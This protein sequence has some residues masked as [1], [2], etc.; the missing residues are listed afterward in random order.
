MTP[1]LPQRRT[2]APIAVIV[3]LLV[4]GVPIALHLGAT[5]AR[6]TPVPRVPTT[7]TSVH[8][9]QHRARPGYVPVPGAQRGKWHTVFQ[10]NF[11]G[12]GRPGKNWDVMTG[13]NIGAVPYAAGNVYLN[14]R[15]HLLIAEHHTASGW[16]SGYVESTRSFEPAPGQSLLVQSRLSMPM[17][18]SLW[19]AFWALA[20]AARHTSAGEPAAGEVDIAESIN[21]AR[22][23]A[24]ILHCGPGKWIG[25][26]GGTRS[27][28]YTDLAGAGSRQGMHTYSWLWANHGRSS[29]IA[30]YIDGQ[31][32]LRLTEARIGA[33]YWHLAFD[34]PYFILYDLAIGGWAQPISHSTPRYAAMVVDSVRVLTS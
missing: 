16:S 30:L 31:L 3:A 8:A 32:D 34:H 28:H 33:R 19:P 27:S 15:G 9:R 14:G 1:R 12:R 22:W 6:A 23:V 7:M 25:P 11:G 5:P 20:S 21:V 17:G 24:Q 13:A 29:Y 4:G 10:D 26:C 18:R 2:L